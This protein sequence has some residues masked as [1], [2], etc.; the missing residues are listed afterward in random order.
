MY[1]KSGS[2]PEVLPPRPQGSAIQM[3]GLNYVIVKSELNFVDDKSKLE[4]FDNIQKV[5][6]N[7]DQ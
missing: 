2:F 1:C 7:Y 6:M 3:P 4:I 5:L